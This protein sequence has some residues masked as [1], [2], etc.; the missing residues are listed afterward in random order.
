MNEVLTKVGQAGDQISTLS[1]HVDVG[2]G[3]VSTVAGTLVMVPS[4]IST[5]KGMSSE[6]EQIIQ[7]AITKYTDTSMMTT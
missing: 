7:A 3:R 6:P 2:T 1:G 5:A 4:S